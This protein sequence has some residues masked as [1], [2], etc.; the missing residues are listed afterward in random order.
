MQ[1]EC[2]ITRDEVHYATDLAILNISERCELE[3]FRRQA[4]RKGDTE[5]ES[6]CIIC[7]ESGCPGIKC[8]NEESPHFICDSCLT[9]FVRT[10]NEEIGTVALLQ[11]QGLV[12][13]P[14]MS[15]G[16]CRCLFPSGFLCQHIAD[17]K[18]IDEYVRGI[19]E[20]QK[21]TLVHDY[22]AQILQNLEE[23]SILYSTYSLYIIRACILI[24]R[25]KLLL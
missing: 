2:S 8:S 21:I 24:F 19:T 10:L 12:L 25:V 22:T 1:A 6:A 23:A 5:V 15:P 11:R 18:V 14:G 20:F 7:D 9:L 17:P 13:C 3:A 16:R 4:R